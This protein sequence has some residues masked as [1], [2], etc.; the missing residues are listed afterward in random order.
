MKFMHIF[1]T[2]AAT[3][4]AKQELAVTRLEHL[5]AL[6]ELEKARASVA[7]REAQVS[8]YEDRIARLEAYTEVV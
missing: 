5:D 6:S 7:W 1:K 4:V 2:P 3:D 8:T